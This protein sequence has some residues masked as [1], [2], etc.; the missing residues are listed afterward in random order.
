M[1]PITRPMLTGSIVGVIMADSTAIMT[2]AKRQFSFKT[3]ALIKPTLASKLTTCT[4]IVTAIVTMASAL[5]TPHPLLKHIL[6]Y[7][8]GA[9]TIVSWGQYMIRGVRIMQK[10]GDGQ[11]NTKH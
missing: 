11:I 6:F 9:V 1:G 7:L 4:Q 5:W 8:T 10:A 3:F 2:T